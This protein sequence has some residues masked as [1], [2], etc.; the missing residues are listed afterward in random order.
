MRHRGSRGA[1][2]RAG[3]IRVD[4]PAPP[5]KNRPTLTMVCLLLA[6]VCVGCGRLRLHQMRSHAARG[7]DAWIVAQ[8]IDCDV[9]SPTCGRLHLVKAEAC[10]R[11]AESGTAPATHFA[12]AAEELDKGITL[13]RSWEDIDEQLGF[14]GRRCDAL[15]RLQRLQSG[16]TA[17]ET[18][19]RLLHAAQTL[20]RLAPDSVPAVYYMSIAWLRQ[21]EP[22]LS[23]VDATNRLP[24]C[25]RLKR[26]VNQVLSRMET[27]RDEQEPEWHRFAERYQ[28]LVFQLGTA[29]HT[30]EC[31]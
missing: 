3:L 26:S 6:L 9:P 10:F 27:A 1:R 24:V 16:T 5:F 20:Y 2:N 28:R 11:L 23:T 22:R 31:R 14:H 29:M 18:R 7:D 8:P 4:D 17:D 25:S 12:C 15:D 30:A 13:K 19:E 21:L